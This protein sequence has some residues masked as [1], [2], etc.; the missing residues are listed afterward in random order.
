M[1][2]VLN[3]IFELR[4]KKS[5]GKLFQFGSQGNFGTDG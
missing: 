3:F 5:D 2:L 4:K 1:N